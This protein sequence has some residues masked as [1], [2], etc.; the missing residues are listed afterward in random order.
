MG[1]R[2]GCLVGM[3]VWVEGVKEEDKEEEVVGCCRR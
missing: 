1:V 2:G 3:V